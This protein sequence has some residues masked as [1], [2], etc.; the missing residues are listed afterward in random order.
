MSCPVCSGVMHNCFQEKVLGK[1]LAQYGACDSCGFLRAHNPTWLDEAYTRAIANADTGLIMR[2]ITLA[3]KISRVL[4]W[5]T[6]K[7]GSGYY[8]DTAGGYGI[9]TR[10]MRDYG[11][12]FYWTDKYCENLVARGFEYS[13]ALGQCSAVTAIEVLEHVVDPKAFIKEVL[14]LSGTSILIF[15]TELYK[16]PPPKP[17]D[18][19]YYSFATGQHIGF[20][21]KQTLERLASDL[22]LRF[23]TANGLHIFSK[24]PI[25]QFKLRL[26][27]NRYLSIFPPFL[28]RRFLGTKML[29]D[30]QEMIKKIVTT[31]ITN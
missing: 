25:N 4:Y 26:I 8:L 12:N 30:H 15:T 1:Y 28:I 13:N 16:G 2:N 18:W 5:L 3:N 10:L 22:G 19:W 24:D 7:Q 23:S 20:F 14:D 31:E 11:F 27:T 29:S 6:P 17:S 9:L 21:K